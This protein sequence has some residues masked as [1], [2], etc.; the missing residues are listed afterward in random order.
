[1]TNKA[2][3]VGTP[4]HIDHGTPQGASEL[5]AQLDAAL[6]LVQGCILAGKYHKHADNSKFWDEAEA[7]LSQKLGI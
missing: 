4:G 7:W 5:K 2:T 6:R 3:N 1:M